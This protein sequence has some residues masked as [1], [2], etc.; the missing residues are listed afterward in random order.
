MI[1][2]ILNVTT[3]MV[4]I[5][6]NMIYFRCQ[7]LLQCKWCKVLVRDEGG[8]RFILYSNWCLATK[9]P[10]Q[11]FIVEIQVNTKTSIVH[12]NSSCLNLEIFT[13]NDYFKKDFVLKLDYCHCCRMF[14][15]LVITPFYFPS[16]IRL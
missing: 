2:K 10:T 7:K 5:V 6:V 1:Y 8:G 16:Y 3:V 14:E 11:S 13:K 15:V 4:R 12:L 9:C